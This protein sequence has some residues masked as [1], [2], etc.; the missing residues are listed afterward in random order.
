MLKKFIDQLLIL[1]D[2]GKIIKA[3]IKWLYVLL[4]VLCFVPFV[5]GFYALVTEWDEVISALGSG[6]WANFVTMFIVDLALIAL[7]IAGLIGFNFWINRKENID[8]TI[9][10][11]SRTVAIPLIADLNQRSGEI[12]SLFIVYF[13]V[14]AVVLG[15]VACLLTGGYEFYQDWNF[16]KALL[17]IVGVV[18]AALVLAYLNLIITR[19]VS[20]RIRLLPQIGNDVQRIAN[21]TDGT[22][23]SAGELEEVD[24]LFPQLTKKEK[25]IA[26]WS[27]I[28]SAICAFLFALWIFIFVGINYSK[29]VYKELSDSQ[30]QQIDESYSGFSSLYYSARNMAEQSEADN[31]ESQYKDISYK[32]LHK[33]TKS[34]LN[35]DDFINK[36]TSAAEKAFNKIFDSEYQQKIDAEKKKWEEYIE[37]HDVN[38]YLTVETVTD[39]YRESDY[40]STYYRPSFYFKYTEPN[41][42]LNNASIT[43]SPMNSSGY[44]DHS[45]D[46]TVTLSEIKDGFATKDNPRHY[47][48][49][50]D[51]DYWDNHTMNVVINSVTLADGNVIKNNANDVP[52]VVK[53]YFEDPND[54]TTD[55][56]IRELIDENYQSKD[57]YT[58]AY[59]KDALKKADPKVF[60]FFEKYG[61]S[62]LF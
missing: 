42:K 61:N 24:F 46:H 19:F 30:I 18:I 47:T 9:R 14:I 54:E 31:T 60:E 11:G 55:A 12:V 22:I 27:V 5:G 16:L 36:Q 29:S 38:K 45:Y 41:G 13:P 35:N 43:F 10:T 6:F 52:K 21:G 8:A 1:S 53:D 34:Y 50:D 48:R 4:G 7:I 20:E 62:Y 39:Y 56:F 2:N 23:A 44:V 25:K 26:L 15:F 49:I 57:E 59:I 40:W 32:D 28:L 3:P 17:L 37:K 33:F 51:S 58:K